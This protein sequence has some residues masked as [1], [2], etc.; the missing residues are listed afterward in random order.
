MFNVQEKHEV[1]EPPDFHVFLYG[2]SN[3]ELRFTNYG[4]FLAAFY[5]SL[6]VIYN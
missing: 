4:R 1:R 3:Y 6:L 5:F 2:S